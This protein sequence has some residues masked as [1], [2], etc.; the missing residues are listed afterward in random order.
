[1][2]ILDIYVIF[3][4]VLIF[5]YVIPI[6]GG[7]FIF[8]KKEHVFFKAIVVYLIL[9]FIISIF[10][11]LSYEYFLEYFNKN[12]HFIYYLHTINLTIF[13]LFFFKSYLIS[14]K[15]HILISGIS[16]TLFTIIEGLYITSFKV[17]NVYSSFIVFLW[18]LSLTMLSIKHLILNRKHQSIRREPLFWLFIGL[19][20][21]ITAN[22][23]HNTTSNAL[24]DYSANSYFMMASFVYLM[25]IVSNILYAKGFYEI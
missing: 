8:K 13:S 2:K 24:I 6:G 15:K 14:F 1:M 17:I 5:S 22:A 25:N 21:S 9:T 11:W 3:L 23:I 20:I 16:L 7:V 19:L 12:T 18:I 4:W 10:D